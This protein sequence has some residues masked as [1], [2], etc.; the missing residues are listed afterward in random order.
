MARYTAPLPT[1]PS[2]GVPG[3]SGLVVMSRNLHIG[4]RG[5]EPPLHSN[6]LPHD[7]RCQ[8]GDTPCDTVVRWEQD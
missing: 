5:I 4:G 8:N 3:C 7:R 1:P 2:P 6:C